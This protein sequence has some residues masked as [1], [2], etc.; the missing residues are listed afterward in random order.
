MSAK[1]CCQCHSVVAPSDLVCPECGS[2]H[3][4]WDDPSE[5]GYEPEEEQ[6]EEENE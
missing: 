5:N 6:D 3:L 4:K 2:E 1:H